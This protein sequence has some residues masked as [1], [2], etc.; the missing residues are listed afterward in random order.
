MSTSAGN[1]GSLANQL[2][3]YESLVLDVKD[4]VRGG[5]T[6]VG[7]RRLFDVGLFVVCLERERP[8]FPRERHST[9]VPHFLFVRSF[10]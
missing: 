1:S 6:R 3:S 9:T 7:T 2:A 10:A 4:E 8:I 5:T